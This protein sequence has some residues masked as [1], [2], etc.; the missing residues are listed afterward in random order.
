MVPVSLDCTWLISGNFASQVMS[1]GLIKCFG[2]AHRNPLD[3]TP[4]E[5]L[6]GGKNS[7]MPSGGWQE[8]GRVWLYSLPFQC[9][10]ILNSVSGMVVLWNTSSP[11]SMSANILNKFATHYP[12]TSFLDWAAVWHAVLSLDSIT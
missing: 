1:I 9:R 11:S 3:Q 12:S 10:R 8:Q 2:L 4:C 5:W 6:Q 7:H